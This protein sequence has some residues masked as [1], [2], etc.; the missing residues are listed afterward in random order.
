MRRRRKL[1]ILENIE[2]LDFAAEGKSIAK[3]DDKVIFI[4]NCI[5]GDIVDIQI[6]KKRKKYL[7]AYPIKFIKRSSDRV[8]SKCEHFGTCGGC[9]W[10]S[11]PYD[12]QLFY[13]EKQVYGT[14]EHLGGVDLS[15]IKR[16]SIVGSDETYYYRNKLEYTFSNKRWLTKEEIESE[17]E[18]EKD[19]ALGFHIPKMF[20]K[21]LDIKNC[22]L[23]P[24]PSNSIRLAIKEYALENDLSFF[25]IRQQEGFLRN[26]IIRTSTTGDV[27]VILSLFFEDKIERVKLLD[28][29]K[30]KFP[31]VTSLQYVINSK[32]N[33]TISDLD[34]VCYHG[35][36]HIFEEM[37]GLRFKISPKSF[38]QTNSKQ[39]YKLY[40]ETRRMAN[41]KPSDNVYDLYTGTGTIANFVAKSCNSVV[42]IEYVD[43]AIKDAKLNSN[44]NSIENTKFYAG[45][46]KDV[47]NDKFI[48]T[49]GVPDVMIIDPPRAGMHAGVVETILRTAPKRLVYV[50]CNPAT[51]SRDI[52]LMSEK[53]EL[54][55][56]QP[57]DMFPHTHHVENIV[58]LELIEK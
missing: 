8:E 40:S 49:H 29:L 25:D 10:Q 31:E 11:L 23:Q 54:K 7:E 20:D 42:G 15:T 53:Y 38:Y 21:I 47:L 18:I 35:E 27:L 37:E 6:S 16:N 41:L 56:V 44:I 12:K 39:A 14:L 52:K 33:D 26:L 32:K 1:P 43:D 9:K 45:D 34:I 57:V 22:Y 13:K 48:K 19:N 58:S 2:I 3:V 30:E 46:M 55:E 50:S 4:Q 24:E 51:Q 28:F 36:D 17:T 5:P